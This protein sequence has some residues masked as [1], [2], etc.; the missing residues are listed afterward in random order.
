MDTEN[1]FIA[2][3]GFAIIQLPAV[4]GAFNGITDFMGSWHYGLAGYGL[5]FIYSQIGIAIALLIIYVIWR[6]TK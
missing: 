5:G 4:S 1:K 6:L 3:A 2:G